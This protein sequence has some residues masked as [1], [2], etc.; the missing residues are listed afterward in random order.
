MQQS[1]FGISLHNAS[2]IHNN[3][4]L[5]KL[6]SNCPAKHVVNAEVDLGGSFEFLVDEMGFDPQ[7]PHGPNEEKSKLRHGATVP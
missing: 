3:G 6:G 1:V 4:D 5:H 7:P 2:A